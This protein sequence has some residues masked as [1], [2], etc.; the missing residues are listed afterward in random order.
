MPRGIKLS[1]R[2]LDAETRKHVAAR[3]Y[4]DEGRTSILHDIGEDGR[5]FEIVQK[6]SFH[7]SLSNIKNL[8]P[9][10][11]SNKLEAVDDENIY[12]SKSSQEKDQTQVRNIAIIS[13]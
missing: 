5:T 8:I 3:T 12:S 1:K 9:P 6:S 11:D 7:P 2:Q 13:A 4:A 10:P